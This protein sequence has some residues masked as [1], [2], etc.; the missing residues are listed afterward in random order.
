MWDGFISQLFSTWGEIWSMWEWM[1][2]HWHSETPCLPIQ[3]TQ[4]SHKVV[5]S[6][7]WELHPTRTKSTKFC[8]WDSTWFNILQRP[9]K[10]TDKYIW[11]QLYKIEAK[12]KSQHYQV[13]V[14]F[15][16]TKPSDI[17]AQLASLPVLS[18]VTAGLGV[19]VF[20]RSPLVRIPGPPDAVS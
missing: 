12:I 16:V 14:H 15:W 7:Q 10:T 8:L 4:K 6:T 17:T 19:L 18:P 9:H 3:S 11:F 13:K 2:Q 1:Y 20:V 5:T